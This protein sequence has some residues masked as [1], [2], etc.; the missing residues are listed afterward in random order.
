MRRPRLQGLAPQKT[1]LA[2]CI[3]L[4][5]G[6]IGAAYRDFATLANA[7]VVAMGFLSEAFMALGMTL[8]VSFSILAALPRGREA[9]Q[10]FKDMIMLLFRHRIAASS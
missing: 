1:V 3:L 9:L 4:L 5:A 10:N 2:V 8:V 7:E 6:G